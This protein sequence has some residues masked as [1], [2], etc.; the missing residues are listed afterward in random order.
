MDR[1]IIISIFVV[2]NF[3]TMINR[4]SFFWGSLAALGGLIIPWRKFQAEESSTE[5]LQIG[6]NHIPKIEKNTTMQTVFHPA[7]S[8]GKANHGWLNSNHTYSFANYYNP[9]RMNFGVLR[10]LN[11][12]II[13]G[14]T[15]FGTHP[16][17]NMEI[18]SIP[19]YGALAHKD[20]MGNSSVIK[21][22]EIQVMSAGSGVQHSEF[23]ASG[24]DDANF[25]QIWVFPN[26]KNVTPRYDQQ[27]LLLHEKPN[28][29]HQILSPFEN[30]PGV[31][32]HQD[33]WFSLGKFTEGT[34]QNYK[35]H[36]SGNGVYV[37]VIEGE[38]KINNQI[39]QK[40]DGLGIWDCNEMDIDI[41]ANSNVLL[42]E[43]PMQ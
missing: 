15:G 21:S 5:G 32:I 30:D 13:K 19:I 2:T 40:R 14:G 33:A 9:N 27:E 1:K 10:V 20:S 23:N 41:Q 35:L 8:R 31:W 34:K 22:N 25:L 18:I 4:R 28:E 24:T 36:K 3:V 43:V 16:H 12:D 17:Q 11:D 42:M 37:F 7:N 6:F 38:V 26:K 39:L 29:F